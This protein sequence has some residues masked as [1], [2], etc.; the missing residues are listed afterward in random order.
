MLPVSKGKNGKHPLNLRSALD[1]T[2]NFPATLQDVGITHQVSVAA[3]ATLLRMWQQVEPPKAMEPK[4]P[5]KDINPRRRI[6]DE[7]AILQDKED[8]DMN[9]MFSLS[10]TSTDEERMQFIADMLTPDPPWHT[11]KRPWQMRTWHHSGKKGRRK[12]LTV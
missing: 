7:D 4:R 6:W 12:K 11:E 5:E 9:F 3:T 1:I 10:A 2:F 8:H